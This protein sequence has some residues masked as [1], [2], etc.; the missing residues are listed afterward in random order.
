MMI[1]HQVH[2]RAVKK[3]TRMFDPFAFRA[4][5]HSDVGVM[6][7]IFGRLA[8]AKPGGQK[9]HQ[10]AIVV[11]HDGTCRLRSS[12]DRQR[13]QGWMI[14][15][16]RPLPPAGSP[17]D[18]HTQYPPPSTDRRPGPGQPLQ[19]GGLAGPAAGRRTGQH[20]AGAA[21]RHRK[22]RHRARHPATTTLRRRRR[23]SLGADSQ[24]ACGGR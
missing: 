24:A 6:G 7:D 22:Q 3:R 12:A 1:D 4:L 14:S 10:L 13:Q 21:R 11:F 17:H 23:P 8:I 18:T 5:Q 15:A 9:T 2:C 16:T 20:R 19:P